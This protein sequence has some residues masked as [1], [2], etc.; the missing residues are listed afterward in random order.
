MGSGRLSFRSGRDASSSSGTPTS[1]AAT[2]GMRAA[3]VKAD[4]DLSLDIAD[5]GSE[6]FSENWKESTTLSRIEAF[7]KEVLGGPSNS[8]SA[9][10]R[11]FSAPLASLRLP[12][13][14]STG[15]PT[16]SPSWHGTIGAAMSIGG[17]AVAATVAA[18]ANSHGGISG[19]Y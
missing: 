6:G 2:A 19:S 18:A 7:R 8:G 5:K 3:A 14:S 15:R 1:A 11:G 17:A 10:S 12:H 13:T 9:Q 16:V 4:R